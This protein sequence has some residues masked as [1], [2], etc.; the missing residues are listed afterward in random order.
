MIG[1][2]MEENSPAMPCGPLLLGPA[3]AGGNFFPGRF[4][5]RK[6]LLHPLSVYYSL[7]KKRWLN[8][9]SPSRTQQ[10]SN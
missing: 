6:M 2:S 4:K 9:S 3:K 8:A 5:P 7:E 10:G 1:E